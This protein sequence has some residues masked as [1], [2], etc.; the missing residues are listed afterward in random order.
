VLKANPATAPEIEGRSDVVGYKYGLARTAD[1]LVFVGLRPWSDERH[2]RCTI[3]RGQQNEAAPFTKA[4]VDQDAESQLLH[5]ESQTPILIPD[6]N[7]DVVK[8]EIR[9]LLMRQRRIFVRQEHGRIEHECDYKSMGVLDMRS[10]HVQGRG[11]IRS[12]GRNGSLSNPS[13]ETSSS[14]DSARLDRVR[15]DRAALNLAGS[16]T[17]RL[18]A[19]SGNS[20]TNRTDVAADSEKVH[21][22]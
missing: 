14:L 17:A 11:T 19:E 18:L 6:E 16:E 2:K 10:E 4:V 9:P 5:V 22:M 20:D 1:E 7:G 15:C 12:G 3:G 13:F 8:A 21:A